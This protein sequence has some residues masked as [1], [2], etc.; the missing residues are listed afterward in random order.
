[1]KTLPFF[2]SIVF[3]VRNQADH[4]KALLEQAT[5]LIEHHVRDYELIIVDNASD[6]QS[7][8]LFQNLTAENGLANL[9]IY[10]LTQQVDRDTASWVGV[11]NALGDYVVIL[12]PMQDEI[13]MISSLLETAIEGYEV[14][15]AKNSVKSQSPWLYRLTNAA[16]NGLFKWFSGIHLANDAPFFRILSKKIVNF[17]LQHSQPAIG[18]RHL[19]ATAGFL[20]TTLNYQAERRSNRHPPFWE[21]FDRAIRLLVSS[22]RAP[23]RLVTSL[24]LFGAVANLVY[25]A[26]VFAIWLFKSDIAPGWISLALQQSG[27]FFLFSMVLFV[28]GEY[29][30]HMMTINA[31]QPSFHIAQ[32]FTSAKLTRQQKLNVETTHHGLSLTNNDSKQRSKIV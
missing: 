31:D 16:F 6:D 4:L 22:T 3:V 25:S 2:L 27:M 18:Y 23:M 24:S 14:V 1:M 5:H 9:Q 10:T 8:G 7:L 32:E 21:N 13:S 12:D 11:E 30:L 26:Y 19:A 20:K 28:L 29:I 15:F 17:L